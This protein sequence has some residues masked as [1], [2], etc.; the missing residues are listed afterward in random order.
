MQSN[1][2][3]N[4]EVTITY[5][6]A[7]FNLQLAVL[8]NHQQLAQTT[9]QNAAREAMEVGAIIQKL[10]EQANVGEPPVIS[11]PRRGR[12]DGAATNA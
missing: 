9:A 7:E 4:D 8:K 10:T 12:R 6:T 5:T 11:E 3:F 2:D 1:H